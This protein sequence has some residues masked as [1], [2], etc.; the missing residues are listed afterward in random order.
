[1]SINHGPIELQ[2]GAT[3]IDEASRDTAYRWSIRRTCVYATQLDRSFVYLSVCLIRRLFNRRRLLN[4]RAFCR[5]T[6]SGPNQWESLAF[7]RALTSRQEQRTD[8]ML[9]DVILEWMTTIVASQARV[10][11]ARTFPKKNSDTFVSY[12]SF[13]L[14]PLLSFTPTVNLSFSLSLSLPSF[15]LTL[16]PVISFFYP[17]LFSHTARQFFPLAIFQR[18]KHPSRR[19]KQSSNSRIN[20][21][22]VRNK[23]TDATG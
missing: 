8:A 4:G 15:Y 14:S 10:T 9:T 5:A 13:V 2:W 12:P 22:N 16:C 21:D 6:F 3:T 17:L 1:M 19:G 20:F 11:N 7:A 18:I 23:N